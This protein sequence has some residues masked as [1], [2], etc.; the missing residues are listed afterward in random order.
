MFFGGSFKVSYFCRTRSPNI[1]T[2]IFLITFSLFY[3]FTPTC[4]ICCIVGRIRNN[5]FE[6]VDHDLKTLIM[7][8]VKTLK[9]FIKTHLKSHLNLKTFKNFS[10]VFEVFKF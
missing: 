1:Y 4:F 6:L 8:V 9:L 10:V 2:K 5:N 7:I 3:W